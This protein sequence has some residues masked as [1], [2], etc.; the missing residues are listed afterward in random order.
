MRCF[1]HE[2][3]AV[4]ICKSCGK[5]ICQDCA[6]DFKKG[7][8]CRGHCEESVQH[9]IQQIKEYDKSAEL[10]RQNAE[11]YKKQSEEQSEEHEACVEKFKKGHAAWEKSMSDYE[12][13]TKFRKPPNN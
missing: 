7:L 13:R 6:I 12:S 10:F 2:N 1:Y 11:L 4:G 3:E 8:A 9:I 5:G